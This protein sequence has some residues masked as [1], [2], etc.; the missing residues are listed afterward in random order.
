MHT[1]NTAGPL[2]LRAFPQDGVDQFVQRNGAYW[3]VVTYR[4]LQAVVPA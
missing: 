1:R 3:Q 2:Q 4:M